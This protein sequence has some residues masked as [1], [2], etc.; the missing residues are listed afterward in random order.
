MM[1]NDEPDDSEDGDDDQKSIASSGARAA[2]PY[3]SNV[4]LGDP[5][6]SLVPYYTRA[7]AALP[8]KLS[9]VDSMESLLA[10]LEESAAVGRKVDMC[11]AGPQP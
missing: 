11:L 5:Q 7:F 6:G 2:A 9:V 10:V 1:A 4:I 3:T 8:A